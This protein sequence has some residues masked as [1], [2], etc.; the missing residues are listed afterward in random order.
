MTWTLVRLGSFALLAIVSVVAAVGLMRAPREGVPA[1]VEPPM[2]EAVPVAAAPSFGA[3][4]AYAAPAPSLAPDPTIRAHLRPELAEGDRARQNGEYDR[5][6]TLLRAAAVNADPAVAHEA[7]LQLAVT[8]LEAGKAGEAAEASRELLGRTPDGA[9]RA[10]AL[11]TLGRAQK[12]VGECGAATTTLREAQAA[13]SPLGAYL[14][15]L[16]AECAA[17]RNDRA[18]QLEVSRM[19]LNGAEARLTKIDA[20]EH[21]VSAALKLKDDETATRANEH[22]VALAAT[23]TYRAQSLLSLG[24]IHADA[25]RRDAAI[26]RFATLVTEL[27]DAPAAAEGLASLGRLEA[28]NR[29]AP[30]DAGAVL[31]FAGRHADAVEQLRM[32]LDGGTLAGEKAARARLNLGVSLLRLGRTD[33]AVGTLRQAASDAAGTDL[34]ARA[35]LRAG[36]GLVAA[37]RPIEGSEVLRLAADALPALAASQE[38]HQELVFTLMMRRANSEAV[39]AARELGDGRADAKWAGLGLLWASKALGRA[40]DPEQANA[41]LRRAAELDRDGF[42]GL[43]AGAIVGGDLRATH[44]ARTLDP[45]SLRTTADDANQ[46]ESWL[47]GHGLGLA[48]LDAE[49]AT[50]GRFVRAGQLYRVGLR[51]WAGWE[52]QDVAT[53][54]EKDAPRLYGLARFASDRGDAQLG[55]RFAAAARRVTGEPL[56]AQPKLLQRLVYPLPFADLLA[57]EAGKRSVDPFVLAALVRQESAFNPRAKSSAGALGL[58]QVMP[59]TGQGIANALG[60]GAFKTDDLL[61]PTVSLEFGAYYLASQLKAYNG[62]LYPALAA[63]NAG[64]GNVNQWLREIST[65]DMDLFAANIPFAETHHYIQ[66][67]YENYRAY[68]RLYSQ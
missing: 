20:L 31:H 68:V 11:T 64:G 48:A 5:A 37:D 15:L 3:S 19:A 49:H 63:Y 65:D 14:E 32:A 27:P 21:A 35:L 17:T 55:M 66:V 61:R 56:A 39:A 53:E 51:D 40:G 62:Q 6:T 8:A 25:G 44:T 50:D 18:A 1:A 43:R 24:T 29:V 33:E 4:P 57:R 22:L 16:L 46:I 9:T 26:A 59:A 10:A 47:S 28:L 7:L 36:R 13:G 52:L 12:H 23:R 34:A 38:A 60:Q 58:G 42:G 2:T 41:L 67:V 30:D 54:Y 45:A